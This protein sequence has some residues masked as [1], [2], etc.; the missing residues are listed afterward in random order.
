MNYKK[1]YLELFNNITD[2]IE[3]LKELQIKAEDTCISN[4]EQDENQ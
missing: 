1:A 2:I 3:L 4:E